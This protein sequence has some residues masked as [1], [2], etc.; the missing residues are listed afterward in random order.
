MRK[1]LCLV[2]AATLLSG[3][4][5]VLIGGAAVGGYYL[6]QDERT[7]DRVIE[8]NAINASVKSRL[9][10]SK[11]VDAFDIK[12]RTY[13]GVVTLKGDVSSFVAKEQA[14]IEANKVTGVVSVDNRIRVVRS[15]EEP[16]PVDSEEAA[17]PRATPLQ[18][19]G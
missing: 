3:C 7:P 8:D 6:G 2:M 12:V 1:T 13:E 5:P 16:E 17:R 19:R 14:E 11:Y 15:A 10:G 18:D 4:V 9:I